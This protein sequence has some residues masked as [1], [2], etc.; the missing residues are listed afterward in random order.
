MVPLF[1]IGLGFF[2]GNPVWGYMVVLKT[3]GRKS[4]KTRYSP[5]NYAIMN[6]SIYC[7]AGWGYV[8][9]WYKNLAAD[10]A[11]E[12]ILPGGSYSGLAEEVAIPGERLKAMRQVLKAGGLAG[13]LFGFNP[14]IIS[15]KDLEINTPGIP[16]IRIRPTGFG[17]G[18]GDY[19]G[20]L[21]VPVLLLFYYFS[22]R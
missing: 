9:D 3:R 1:R 13:F 16:V 2:W 19:G 15:D 7:V 22:H 8:A 17:V 12:M 5:V 11:I 4:G 20:W 14:F 10:P 6:G 21:W 18:A